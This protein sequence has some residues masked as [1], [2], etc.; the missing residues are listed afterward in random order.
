MSA[1]QTENGLE[2][3]VYSNRPWSGKICFD[4]P[5]H[6]RFLGMPKDYPRI[7]SFPEWHTIDPLSVYVIGEKGGK[8]M[9]IIGEN[10]IKGHDVKLKAKSPLR[11]NITP[12]SQ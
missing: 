4:P 9:N 3:F 11:L 6:S 12:K 7:N 10:L 8:Q 1:E 5:R 2:V